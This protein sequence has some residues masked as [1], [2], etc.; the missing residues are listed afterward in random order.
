MV[1]SLRCLDSWASFLTFVSL[2]FLICKM[3]IIILLTAKNWCECK[4]ESTHKWFF[5]SPQHK[6]NFTNSNHCYVNL[7]HQ[8]FYLYILSF[9]PRGG[10]C[11]T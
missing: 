11:L 10:G 9:P 3:G 2:N 1:L 5:Q 8:L 4:Q 6:A 7:P